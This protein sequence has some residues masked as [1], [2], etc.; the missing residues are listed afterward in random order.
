LLKDAIAEHAT[1]GGAK[2]R[3]MAGLPFSPLAEC[4]FMKMEITTIR[5]KKMPAPKHIADTLIPK[6]P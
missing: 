3:N 1:E 5:Y 6:Y 4:K 2:I